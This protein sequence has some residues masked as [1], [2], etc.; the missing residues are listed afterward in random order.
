MHRS[1]QGGHH[2]ARDAQS[3]RRQDVGE[4]RLH[5]FLAAPVRS[6]AGAADHGHVDTLSARSGGMQRL[7]GRGGQRALR[8]LPPG[9]NVIAGPAARRPEDGAVARRHHT[10]RART[11]RI[12]GHD[13]LLH[14]H[15]AS[16]TH[17]VPGMLPRA[18]APFASASLVTGTHRGHRTEVQLGIRRWL[19]RDGPRR[20][21]VAAPRALPPLRTAR[22]RRQ[23]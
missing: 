4:H 1:P 21:A 18:T 11:A 9:Q 13:D 20:P 14:A 19:P 15:S 22:N 10:A 16:V 6:D 3:V 17:G 5:E 7:G 2:V 23:R 12:D 8:R